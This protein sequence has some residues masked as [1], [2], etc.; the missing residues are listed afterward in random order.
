MFTG[1]AVFDVLLPGDSRNLKAKR[2]Y[3]RPLLA[4]LKKYEVSVAEVGDQDVHG[5]MQIGVAVV[6]GD[7]AHVRDVLDR[8]ERQFGM[9]PE[10]QLLSVRRRLHGD[11]D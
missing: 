5:R 1:T 10:L 9:M 4:A 7:A 2:A 8:C 3:V 11:E 6:S